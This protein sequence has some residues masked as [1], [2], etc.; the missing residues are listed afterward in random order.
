MLCNMPKILG[1][2]TPQRLIDSFTHRTHLPPID[3]VLATVRCIGPC[4]CPVARETDDGKETHAPGV[5]YRGLGRRL[6]EVVTFL[7]R[8][9]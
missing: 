3:I 7:G 8:R 2:G 4:T 1:K 6:R 9:S 5:G